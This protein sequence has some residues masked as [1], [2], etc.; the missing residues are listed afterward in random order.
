MQKREAVG[1]EMAEIL[2]LLGQVSCTSSQKPLRNARRTRSWKIGVHFRAMVTTHIF[3]LVFPQVLE[4]TAAAQFSMCKSVEESLAMSLVAFVETEIKTV[5]IL[6]HESDETTESAEQ[7]YAKYLNGK[8]NFNEPSGDISRK[9]SAKLGIG[10]SFKNCSTKQV[11][12]RRTMVR[13]NPMMD[14]EMTSWKRRPR[15]PMFA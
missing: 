11:E 2:E 10:M 8:I 7:V 1:E 5:A 12:R 3:C 14:I 13:K 15:P 9:Q 6:Q 4:D